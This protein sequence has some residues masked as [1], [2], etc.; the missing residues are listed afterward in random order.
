MSFD[1]LFDGSDAH[2]LGD[3]RTDF[4]KWHEE[5]YGKTSDH[6]NTKEARWKVWKAASQNQREKCIEACS[7]PVHNVGHPGTAFAVQNMCIEAIKQLESN[8]RS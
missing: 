3:E 4:E 1:K 5:Y 7:M 2:L 8:E 6:S